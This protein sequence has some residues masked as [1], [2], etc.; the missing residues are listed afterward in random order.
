ADAAGNGG[1]RPGNVDGIGMN[2]ADEDRAFGAEFFEARGEIPEKPLGSGGILDGVGAHIDDRSTGFQP[3][4]LHEPG[5]AHGGNDDV[6]A[7]DDFGK[8]ARFGVA[9]GDGRVGVHEQKRHRLADNI[10]AAEHA[11]VGPLDADL[12]GERNLHATRGGG[13]D[14]AGTLTEQ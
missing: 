8:V 12:A 4:G 2:V 7:A 9:D 14:N 11:G 10:A 5:F 1:D 13:D 6:G 3:I